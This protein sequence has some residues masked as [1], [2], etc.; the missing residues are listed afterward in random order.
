MNRRD[1]IKLGLYG[2]AGG[3]LHLMRLDS[4]VLAWAL[5]E[6][7]ATR[8]KHKRHKK[9]GNGAFSSTLPI[10]P[11]AQ[12]IAASSLP[13]APVV[14]GATYYDVTMRQGLVQ[15]FP[16]GPATA[17]WGY[18][19][20][21]AGTTFSRS[22]GH[23]GPTFVAKI[24]EPVV[25]RMNNDLP[26]ATTTAIVH[27][28]GAHTPSGSDGSALFSQQI[29][30]GTFRDY[31][32]PND[33]DI[34]ATH[35]YHDHDID[36]TGHNVF[37]GLQGY[38]L[39]WD[40]VERGLNLP[41]NSVNDPP[42]VI[43]GQTM[44]PF[45]LPLV[46][47]DRQ[48]DTNNQIAFDPFNHDGMLGDTFLVNGAILPHVTVANRRYRLRL[49][50]GCNARF[51]QFSLSDARVP[52]WVV[53]SDG[54]LA[55]GPTLVDSILMGPAERVEVIV[56]FSAITP[57][58]T[59]QVFLRNCMAQT[60]GRKPDG[61][62]T[63]CTDAPPGPDG[64]GGLLRFDV[65]FTAPDNTFNPAIQTT[66]RT[67]LPVFD[68]NAPGLVT[69][70]WVFNRSNG[71]WQIN[72]QFFDPGPAPPAA[73]NPRID[74]KITH[75]ATEIWRLI[76]GGGGWYHPI[77]IHRNQFYMLDRNGSAA[78]L[79]PHESGGLKDVFVLEGGDVVRVIT[80]YDGIV[81]D[82]SGLYVMHCHNIEHEDMR[83]MIVFQVL[84]PV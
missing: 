3:I 28:H 76:N 38:F 11:V 65:A 66:L 41:G 84:P 71:A 27:H 45:E 5:D 24:G 35:W 81:T 4:G 82:Q 40:D 53:G 69:R 61:L 60:N 43:G 18:D 47:Q 7:S 48:F 44:P 31:V 19:A 77:H 79:R 10:P 57:G 59:S 55:L 29:P 25:V 20:P 1:L 23:L 50:N 75:G 9:T 51:L 36:V 2:G 17:F 16:T 8:H 12:P 72:G 52:M 80:R 37:L 83:M 78:N 33:D 6:K 39:L 62:A 58:S 68:V 30:N 64:V 15:Y 42:A 22:R 73:E 70:D 67:D 34:S 54:G 32:Y 56:D 14:P 49:L 13:G 63:T 74:A 21:L 26:G 46:I